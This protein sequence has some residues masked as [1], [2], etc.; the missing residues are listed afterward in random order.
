MSEEVAE[1]HARVDSC[2]DELFVV[3]ALVVVYYDLFIVCCVIFE[4]LF[5]VV[6][7][8]C[9]KQP[10]DRADKKPAAFDV[11]EELGWM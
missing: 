9:E 3:R 8:S 5:G 7:L 4:A 10:I 6:L 2:G 1:I 11:G